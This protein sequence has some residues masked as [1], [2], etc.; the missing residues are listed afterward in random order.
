M[1][2]ILH[3][4]MT[5]ELGYRRYGAFGGDIGG[6]V[7]A[8]M[9]AE[10]P[11]SVEGLHMIHPPYPTSFDDAPATPPEQA[12]IDAE[13][14]YDETDAGYSWIMATRPDTIA[15]AL[16]DSPVGLAAWIVDKY[17]DWSDCSGD[18]ERRFDRDLLLTILTLYWA[19]GSI[20]SSFRSY[21]DYRH[22]LARPPITVPTAFTVATEPSLAGFP[23]SLTERVCTDIRHWS[24]PGR[25]VTSCRS[26]SR[27]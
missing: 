19:T 24:E 8:W 9:A 11:D 26:R 7:A 16:V 23:R 22:N 15:A 14:A 4:L 10:H 3:R 13:A 12:F 20:G 1:A 5:D 17:R 25:V 2:G 6:A 27:S 18:I 21:Y